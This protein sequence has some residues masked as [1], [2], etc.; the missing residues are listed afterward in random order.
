MDGG[1][2]DGV[3]ANNGFNEREVRCSVAFEY[4]QEWVLSYLER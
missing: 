3:L 1:L 4:V 2:Y